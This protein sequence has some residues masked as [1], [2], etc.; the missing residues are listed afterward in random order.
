MPIGWAVAACSSRAI[1]VRGE[2]VLCPLIDLGNHAAKGEATCEVRVAAGGAVELVALRDVAR[3]DA[4]TRCYGDRL[5]NDDFLLDF[6]FVP[7]ANA[8]D[9]AALAW[10]R[11]AEVRWLSPPRARVAEGGSGR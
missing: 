6:G 3:G 2:R 4:L 1:V 5:S 7:P 9:G 11:V 8:H 10:A